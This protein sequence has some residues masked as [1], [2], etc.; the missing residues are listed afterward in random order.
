MYWHLKWIVRKET[1]NYIKLII[2]DEKLTWFRELWRKFTE[3]QDK[4]WSMSRA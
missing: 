3:S 4:L 1:D 2:I